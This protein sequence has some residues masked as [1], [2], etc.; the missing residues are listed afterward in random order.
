M[1]EI[2]SG[3]DDQG[4]RKNEVT[5]KIQ[6]NSET[7]EQKEGDDRHEEFHNWILKGYRLMAA[8]APTLQE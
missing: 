8:S 7:F 5:H 2:D 3:D 1:G 4:S 6:G